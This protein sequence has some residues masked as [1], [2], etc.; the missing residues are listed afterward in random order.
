MTAEPF[1][2]HL[3]G[4]EQCRSQPFGLCAEGAKLLA[5]QAFDFTTRRDVKP[6]VETEVCAWCDRRGYGRIKLSD[7]LIETAC[8]MHIQG[9]ES[10]LPAR[11]RREA[12][13]R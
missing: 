9:P 4:C 6:P 5:Q 8:W 12:Q 2:D 1:H 7:G 13:R 11:V 3:D 10:R